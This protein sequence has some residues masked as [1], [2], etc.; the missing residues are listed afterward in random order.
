MCADQKQC[1]PEDY[2]CDGGAGEPDCADGSDEANCPALS[3]D[4][5]TCGFYPKLRNKIMK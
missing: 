2:L 5:L 4:K 3:I 1:I